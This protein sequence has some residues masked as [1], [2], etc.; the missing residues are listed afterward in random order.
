MK[1]PINSKS[2]SGEGK[3]RPPRPF[4]LSRSAHV[5]GPQILRFSVCFVLFVLNLA[6]RQIRLRHLLKI[7]LLR[8]KADL[9]IRTPCASVF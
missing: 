2:S 4:R 7:E 9:L 5:S 6:D 8:P 3:A 1:G